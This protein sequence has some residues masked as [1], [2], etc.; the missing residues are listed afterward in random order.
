MPD[1]TAQ[2]HQNLGASGQVAI[3]S[4]VYSKRAPPAD[5]KATNNRFLGIT[6]PPLI[7]YK[8]AINLFLL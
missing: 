3:R 1:N 7:L 8:K 4:K 2:N 6:L 5:P